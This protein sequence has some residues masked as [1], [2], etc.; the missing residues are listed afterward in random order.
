MPVAKTQPVYPPDPGKALE[1]DWGIAASEHV[2]QRFTDIA[3][4]STKWTTPPTGAVCITLAPSLTSWIYD[5]S[6]WIPLGGILIGEVKM[7]PGV[8]TP[9]NWFPCD[10]RALSRTAY[11]ALFA[12]IGTVWGPGDNTTTFNIPDFRGRGPVGVG[13]GVG[14]TDRPLASKFGA[15]N[16]TLAADQL[17]VH[18]HTINH[19]HGSATSGAGTNHAHSGTTG[20]ESAGHVHETGLGVSYNFLIQTHSVE[21]L[22]AGLDLKTPGA[23]VVESNTTSYNLSGHTHNFT[24][25]NEASHTHSV[26]LPL[27][28]GT[29]GSTGL[30]NGHPNVQPSVA[31][32]FIIFAGAG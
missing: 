21:P 20:G 14:L 31:V 4:R 25:G 15:E 28:T 5:G 2:I 19:D 26:D 7:W 9:I 18:T 6:Q 23:R 13:T 12:A 3:D 10:G 1:A 29:S 16:V 32:G 24:T 8:A 22:N 30:G 27:F 11:A 17:P